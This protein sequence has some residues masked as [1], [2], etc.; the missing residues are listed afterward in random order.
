MNNEGIIK[1]RDKLRAIDKNIAFRLTFDSLIIVDEGKNAFVKWNDDEGYFTAAMQNR[2]AM[3]RPREPIEILMAGYDQIQCMTVRADKQT[4]PALLKALG[5]S[6]EQISNIVDHFIPDH[7]QSV[8]LIPKNI[9]KAKEEYLNKQ[10]E[11]RITDLNKEEEQ[12]AKNNLDSIT[13]KVYNK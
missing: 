5:Y 9:A 8:N 10:K 4:A 6:D 11:Q 12:L 13:H 3:N 7:S 1:Y 2:D